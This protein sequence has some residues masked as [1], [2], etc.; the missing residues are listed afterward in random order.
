MV[1]I[2]TLMDFACG[3]RSLLMSTYERLDI[4]QVGDVT[5]VRFRDHKIVEDINIQQLGQA[6]PGSAGAD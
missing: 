5:V 3:R 4:D 1:R 2:G 6:H